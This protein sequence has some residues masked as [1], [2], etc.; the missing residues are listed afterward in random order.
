MFALVFA[1]T[2]AVSATANAEDVIE[3]DEASDLAGPGNYKL[4]KDIVTSDTWGIV[5]TDQEPVTATLDLNGFGIRKQNSGSVISV[6]T[7]ATLSIEDSNN[8]STHYITLE[9]WRGKDV[10]DEGTAT[11]LNNGSGILKVSG[12]YITG[13]MANSHGVIGG[14]IS[15]TGGN[16][17]VPGGHVIMK[18]GTVI[19]N[20]NQYTPDY[21]YGGGGVAVDG[22]GIFEMQGGAITSNHSV[23]GGGV[24]LHGNGQFVLDGGKI[25]GNNATANAGG[26]YATGNG[27]TFEL[28]GGSVDANT[29]AI[30]GGISVRGHGILNMTG[31]SVTGNKAKQNGGGIYLYSDTDH[32]QEGTGLITVSG[33]KVADNVANE[34]GG[35]IYVL[36]GVF[37]LSGGPEIKDNKEK[38]SD[39]SSTAPSNV[40]L[41]NNQKITITGELTNTTPI[42]IKRN[43]GIFTTGLTDNGTANNFVSNREGLGVY[44]VSE[45]GDNYGE[46]QLGTDEWKSLQNALLGVKDGDTINVRDFDFDS[47]YKITAGEDDTCLEIWGAPDQYDDPYKVKLD[48]NGVTL[49]RGLSDSDAAED[50]CVLNLYTVLDLTII[51]TSVDN[52]V[53]TITGGNFLD[54]RGGGGIKIGTD[55]SLTLQDGVVTG[56]KSSEFGG[57][58]FVAGKLTLKGAPKITGNKAGEISTDNNV[59]LTTNNNV[60]ATITIVDNLENEKGEKAEVGVTTEAKPTAETPVAVT[61][62][63][64][65]PYSVASKFTSDIPDYVTLQRKAVVYLAVPVKVTYDKNSGEAKGKMD[66]QTMPGGL[67]DKLASNEFTWSKHTFKEWNTQA[68]G[69]GTSYKDG[70][71]VTMTK[72]TTLYAQWKEDPVKPEPIPEPD[73]EPVVKKSYGLL[74]AKMTSGKKSIKFT[75][76]QLKNVDGYKIYMSECNSSDKKIQPK[77]VVTI[78]NGSKTNWT[79]SGLKEHTAYKAYVQAYVKKNGKKVSVARSF[80]VHAFTSGGDKNFTNPKS[81]SVKKAKVTLKKDKSFKIRAKVK[82]LNKRKMLLSKKHAPKL[83]YYSTNNKVATVSKNGKIKAIGKGNCKIYVVAVNGAKKT[84]RVKVKRK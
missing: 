46:A 16:S 84:V 35:G 33:G 20:V 72:D 77:K 81:V 47:D 45:D 29:A 13:G 51:G 36:G 49:D 64:P 30:G 76:N 22:R 26:V 37:N 32:P 61:G 5:G 25:S 31:G 23:N 62:K 50:G 14:G 54:S 63:V 10:A 67:V 3:V 65:N 48:L 12:G 41:D 6:G 57:G 56:N 79:K 66:P 53:G 39:G 42:G 8:A 78:T 71:E 43:E 60:N 24:A 34:N 1:V 82:K 2:L 70:A 4:I 18:G 75:W 68:D 9:N 28:K 69:K 52:H 7:N 21:D 58:I 11:E 40:A 44:A 15:V 83:R 59:Y 74:T 19:G 38:I 27:A 55:V 80:W 17:D 73:P